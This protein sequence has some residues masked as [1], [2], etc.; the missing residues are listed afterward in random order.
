MSE[1][2]IFVL[3]NIHNIDIYSWE[4]FND[5]KTDIL[6]YNQGYTWYNILSNFN[7]KIHVPRV[8]QSMFHIYSLINNYLNNF[9][10]NNPNI[11]LKLGST[12]QPALEALFNALQLIYHFNKNN[13]NIRSYI[14]SY[15][16]NA[17]LL[18]FNNNIVFNSNMDNIYGLYVATTYFFENEDS[19]GTRNPN[20]STNRNPNLTTPVKNPKDECSAKILTISSRSAPNLRTFCS[21]ET[22]PCGI[23]YVPKGMDKT[24]LNNSTCYRCL[25]EVCNK[26]RGMR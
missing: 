18:Q 13:I 11:D 4:L 20:R 23:A 17:K 19:I 5:P 25:E 21:S 6:W 24:K 10:F 16:Q 8:D 12:S 2:L 9:I 22:K 26:T 1:S 7:V 15:F 3:S 14:S